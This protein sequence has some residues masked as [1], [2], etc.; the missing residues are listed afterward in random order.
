[1]KKFSPFWVIKKKKYVSYLC[2]K[3][4]HHQKIK[5]MKNPVILKSEKRSTASWSKKRLLTA[6][7]FIA[8]TCAGFA[9][10]VIITR[11]AKRIEAKVT[12]I[13]LDVIRYKNSKNL[14]GPTYVLP[15]S[16]IATITF[17]NGRTETY[18]TV[19][20]KPSVPEPVKKDCDIIITKDSRTIEAK[21]T[22]IDINEIRYKNYNNLDGATYSLAKGEIVSITYQNGRVEVFETESL[23]PS[24]TVQAPSEPVQ[25][26]Y[27][28]V[29][30]LTEPVQTPDQL[31]V[32]PANNIVAEADGD[33][34]ILHIYR[35]GR[36]AGAIIGYNVHLGEEQI[37]RVTNNSKT[38]IQV[39]S[40]GQ[41]TLWARTES[42]AEVQLNIEPGREYYIRCGVRFG[43]AVGRPSLE[44]V[45]GKV[46][47]TEISSIK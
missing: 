19:I 39:R 12:E 1:M 47:K 6:V 45:D 27:E 5:K 4:N 16:E 44:L 46:G 26:P 38:T 36:A 43:V 23:T 34:A 25:T 13:D 17:P 24:L 32:Q 42:R 31:P 14:D 21:V 18:G 20:S 10:D 15:I 30:A 9:Q 41:N 33:Y 37:C 40:F 22:E 11:D 7:C 3:F 28:P 2:S 29:Q 35:P 8:L